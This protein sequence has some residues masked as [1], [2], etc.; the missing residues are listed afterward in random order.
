M[1]QKR[2]LGPNADPR[3][4]A[5]RPT[6]QECLLNTETRSDLP[7]SLNVKAGRGQNWQTNMKGVEAKIQS[8]KPKQDP[9][10]EKQKHWEHWS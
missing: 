5:Y 8:T 6:V 9:E 4:R 3:A 10:T 7:S 2:G 1:Y